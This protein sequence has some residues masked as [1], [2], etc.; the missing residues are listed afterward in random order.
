RRNSKTSKSGRST[1]FDDRSY[2]HRGAVELL[3]FKRIIIR[4]ERL[5]RTYQAFINLASIL[6]LWRV[7]K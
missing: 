5:V 1:R 4:H 3:S 2:K 7:L 6:I